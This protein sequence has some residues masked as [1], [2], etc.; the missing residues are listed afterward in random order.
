VTAPT[1]SA[2]SGSGVE[3][4]PRAPRLHWDRIVL[5]LLIIAVGV[6]AIVDAAGF[7]VPWLLVPSVALLVVGLALVFSLAG[8]HGRV[9][10]VVTGAVLLVVAGAVGI[11]ADRF[12]GP[13]GDRTIVPVAG[14]W[15]SST[16]LAAGTALIDLTRAPLPPTGELDVHVGAGKVVLRLPESA[17]VA[18]DASVVAGAVSVDDETVREG[19]DMRWTDPRTAD[20]PLRVTVD[21]GAGNL[22]VHHVRS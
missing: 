8:G 7:S 1:V 2:G 19:V 5:G 9:N 10:L 18:I 3:P 21:I 15:P 4:T 12:A 20:A 13:V 16:T 22:E 17:T 6:S 11:G 14:D